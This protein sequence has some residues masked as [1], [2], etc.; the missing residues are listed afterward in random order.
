[1]SEFLNCGGGDFARVLSTLGEIRWKGVTILDF[2]DA[3]P[4]L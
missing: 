4:K 3:V 1:M 2:V